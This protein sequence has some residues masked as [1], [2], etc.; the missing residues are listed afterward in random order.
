MILFHLFVILD[1]IKHSEG[2]HKVE[3]DGDYDLYQKPAVKPLLVNASLN[4]RNI[5]KISTREQTISLEIT[6]RLFWKD[7]RVKLKIDKN[8][9]ELPRD[10]T[11]H[12][13]SYMVKTGDQINEFWMPDLFVDEVIQMRDPFYKLPT[14]SLRVYE[15]STMRFSNRF[16]FDVVCHMDFKAFPVDQQFC[17]VKFESFGFTEEDIK[18][19]WLENSLMITNPDII[20]PHYSFQVFSDKM[21]QTDYYSQSYPGLELKIH[22][23]RKINYN[24]VQTFIPSILYVSIA[25]F[26][27]LVPPKMLT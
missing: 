11:F 7:Q 27:I 13:L 9:L 14:E 20:L 17:I 5:I 22:L 26:A 24:I 12:N 1:V 15:D 3:K 6:L 21:Y 16:N 18:F 8:Y 23:N 2:V 4:L 10:P 25:Y 19:N